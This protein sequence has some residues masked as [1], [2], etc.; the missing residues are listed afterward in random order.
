MRVGS[1][2]GIDVGSVRIGVATSDPS[3]M[4]ATPVETVRRGEGDLR[5]LAELVAEYEP[6]EVIVGLPRRLSGDEGPAAEAARAFAA[7]LAEEIEPC[8][9]RL[10]DERMTT[11]VATRQ[12]RDS[13]VSSRK[14]RA[15]VDQAA[16]SVILQTALDAERN[17]GTPP[18]EL[19]RF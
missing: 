15:S 2:L 4:L 6:I 13:G 16:A 14:G 5:R 11:V 3:G 17:S 10:I 1:R 12:M 9:V 19:V 7:Q 8:P 18:G